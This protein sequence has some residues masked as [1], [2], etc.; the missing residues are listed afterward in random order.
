MMTHSR[1][2]LL[3]CIGAG[4]LLSAGRPVHAGMMGDHQKVDLDGGWNPDVAFDPDHG[5]YLVVW[6]GNGV[7]GR[8]IDRN[9]V[10]MGA[11]FRIDDSSLACYNGYAAV[12]YSHAR[13]EF[14]VTWDNCTIYGRR[15]RSPD[16]AMQEPGFPISTV[17]GAQRSGVAWGSGSG[18]YLVVYSNF[19]AAYGQRVSGTGQLVGG[20]L[21]LGGYA[22]PTVAYSPS[23]D[24]FL[25][26]WDDG[27]GRI[28]GR[29]IPA[30]YTL[31]MG[32]SFLVTS[33]GHEERATSVHDDALARW[34]VQYQ[35]EVSG[36]DQYVQFVNDNGTLG[37]G[38]LPA[39][40]RPGFE[41]ETN[42]GCD[43]AFS[44]GA[45]LY[46][47]LYGSNE[48][49]IWGQ[50]LDRDGNRVRARFNIG[51]GNFNLH[52][53]AADSALDRFIAVYSD[54]NN[55]AVY[56]HLYAAYVPVTGPSAVAEPGRI[57]LSWTQ[58]TD[59]DMTH[60]AIRYSNSGTPTGP[61]DGTLAADV[62]VEPGTEGSFVHVGL[63]HNL[64]YY[65]A[66]F[67][68]D[69]ADTLYAPGVPT[70]AKPALPGD[71]DGD[72]DVDQKDFGVFQACLAGSGEPYPPGCASADLAGDGD[73]DVD[74]EDFGVFITCV[75]GAGQAPGC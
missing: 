54:A 8:F 74:Q 41:G 75:G 31:P 18:C 38:P 48:N 68:Y 67:A 56:Y 36:F 35:E 16:G 12:A 19:A 5:V 64:T 37:P 39:A 32:S 62:A 46:L 9:G 11:T 7:S 70:S 55:T 45:G 71:L 53:D 59:T 58:P 14:L 28:L 26:T 65:Y 52:S 2:T 63:D 10:L 49:G 73:G 24:V 60:V 15:V 30:N 6:S 51:P 61:G 34:L 66:L 29:R 27:A 20:E 57:R 1:L 4:T 69:G 33:L 47:S 40:N 42:L 13:S 44:A 21:A 43:I 72:G 25:A 23:A 22:Y 3:V 17:A 50:L